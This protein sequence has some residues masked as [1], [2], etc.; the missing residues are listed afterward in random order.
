MGMLLKVHDAADAHLG[1]GKIAA[2][3]QLQP[4]WHCHHAALS[5]SA[6]LQASAKDDACCSSKAEPWVGGLPDRNAPIRGRG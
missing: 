6:L 4:W 2:I 3:V 1:E 5:A